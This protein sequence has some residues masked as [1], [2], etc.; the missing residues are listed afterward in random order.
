LTVTFDLFHPSAI[1]SRSSLKKICTSLAQGV[2][3]TRELT[4]LVNTLLWRDTGKG[5]SHGH[6]VERGRAASECDFLG[7]V[8]DIGIGGERDGQALV[9]D[10]ARGGSVVI[11]HTRVGIRESA[12][13]GFVEVE[14]VAEGKVA[15][16]YRGIALDQTV[17]ASME[18]RI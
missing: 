1:G 13:N 18:V 5:I 9:L 15:T 14:V 17:P 10:L 12:E 11:I 2:S 3:N 4:M 7:C 16:R 8:R 6:K